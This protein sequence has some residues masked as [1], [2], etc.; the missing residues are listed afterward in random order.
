MA[1]ATAGEV[2]QAIEPNVLYRLE[3]LKKRSGLGD[4]AMR[5]ARKNGLKV[6]RKAGKAFVFGGDF[7][8][9][10]RRQDDPN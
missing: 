9:Y 4:W 8:E 7:I 1:T 2:E 5:T 3:E 6:I 10:M